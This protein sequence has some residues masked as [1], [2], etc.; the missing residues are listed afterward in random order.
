[1]E[2]YASIGSWREGVSHEGVRLGL[3]FRHFAGVGT[4]LVSVQ[5]ESTSPGIWSRRLAGAGLEFRQIRGQG[6]GCRV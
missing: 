2:C 3:G 5:Q 1:M 6:V 4:R